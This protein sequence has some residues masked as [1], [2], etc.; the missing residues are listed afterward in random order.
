MPVSG[1]GT[2]DALEVFGALWEGA[3]GEF[4]GV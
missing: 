1:F 3:S 2:P 4:G